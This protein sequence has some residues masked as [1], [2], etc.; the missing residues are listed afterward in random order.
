MKKLSWLFLSLAML[1]VACDPLGMEEATDANLL[2]TSVVSIPNSNGGIVPLIIPGDNNGGNVT[3]A[4]AATQYGVTGG[5]AYTSGKLD[6]DENTGMFSGSWPSEL[7]VTVT[8]KTYVSW[9][10][11]PPAGMCLANMA[12]IVKGSNAANV[13]FYPDGSVLADSGLASP[14]NSSGNPSGL[15]NLTFCWNLTPCAP[16]PVC[17]EETAF[18]GSTPGM[19]NAWW[20]AYDTQVG[21]QQPIYAGQKAVDGAFVEVINDV[22]YITLGPNMQLQPIT[23][24]TKTNPKTG[25]TTTSTNNEQVKVQGY[26]TLPTDRPAAGLFTLYKGR[27]LTVQG[28]GSRYY[29]IHL[30]VEVC[31]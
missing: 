25:V 2:T 26:M 10:F 27:N 15:S 6:Y 13:Y 22:I 7:T 21:G 11:T 17:E 30:D 19:G 3:C 12:V 8:D 16:P 18:G 29:I 31:E 20:F 4:E 28:N 14:V 24:T 23:T 5:F 1:L 9:T